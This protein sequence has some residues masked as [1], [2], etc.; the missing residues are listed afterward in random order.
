[1]THFKGKCSCPQKDDFGYY[2]LFVAAKLVTG[3][4]KIRYWRTILSTVRNVS[5]KLW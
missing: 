3:L 5:R 4:E 1:M 2:V